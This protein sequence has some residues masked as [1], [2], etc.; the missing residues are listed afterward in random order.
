MKPQLT[1][2]PQHVQMKFESGVE[3]LSKYVPAA[4]HRDLTFIGLPVEVLEGLPSGKKTQKNHPKKIKVSNI[5]KLQ[6]S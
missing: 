3:I 1:F 5:F 6:F 4:A 2:F